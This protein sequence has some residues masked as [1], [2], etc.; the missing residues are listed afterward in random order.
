[1]SSVPEAPPLSETIRKGMGQVTPE[2]GCALPRGGRWATSGR[3]RRVQRRP[4][5]FWDLGRAGAARQRVLRASGTP[6]DAAA[7]TWPCLGNTV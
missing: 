2:V 6:A 3:E 4:T 7:M 5:S 1:M